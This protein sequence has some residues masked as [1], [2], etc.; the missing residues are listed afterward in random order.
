MSSTLTIC[1]VHRRLHRRLQDH[2]DPHVHELLRLA[3]TMGKKMD[4]KLRQYKHNYSEGWWPQ[5]K[6][7]GGELDGAETRDEVG[8][9]DDA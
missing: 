2:P 3:F 1:E 6:L 9:V 7:D 8:G 5:H 4:N